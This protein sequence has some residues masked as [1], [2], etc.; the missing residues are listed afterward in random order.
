MK[1]LDTLHEF[2]DLIDSIE[3]VEFVEEEHISKCRIKAGLIDASIL[4]IREVRIKNQLIAYS[5]YWLR[6]DNSIIFGWDNAPHHKEVDTFPHHKHV[7][8]KVESSA[9][10]NLKE[11]LEYIRDFLS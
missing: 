2:D 1:I 11:V 4:W 10:T 5:Y 8:G 9:Q 6:T 3:I 7:G